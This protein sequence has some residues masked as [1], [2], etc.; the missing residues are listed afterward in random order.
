MQMNK[1]TVLPVA[2]PSC[3]S[4]PVA[5]AAA[6]CVDPWEDLGLSDPV[7]CTSTAT[8][9]TPQKNHHKAALPNDK[10]GQVERA[11]SDSLH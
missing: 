7:H 5:P 3:S 2:L 10:A 8:R 4:L 9:K 1:S 11:V 6:F